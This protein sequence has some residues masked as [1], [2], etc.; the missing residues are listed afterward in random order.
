M[1]VLELKKKV[2]YYIEGGNNLKSFLGE[3]QLRDL[4]KL[5]NDLNDALSDSE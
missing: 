2:R 5:L 4:K 3:Q 1:E